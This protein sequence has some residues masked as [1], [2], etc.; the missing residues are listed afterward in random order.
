MSGRER[1]K[2]YLQALVASLELTA[3]RLFALFFPNEGLTL[4]GARAAL[5]DVK[6]LNANHF[7]FSVVI[8]NNAVTHFFRLNDGGIIKPQ[9]KGVVYTKF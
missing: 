5:T 7:T 1:K 6:H 8:Q 4:P 9:V 3:F 2:R